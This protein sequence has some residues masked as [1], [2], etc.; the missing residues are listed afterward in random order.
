MAKTRK[1]KR[2]FKLYLVRH[3][4]S[5]ANLARTNSA[6]AADLYT[7]PELTKEGARRARA[8]RPFIKRVI[9]S[10]FV[11]GASSLMRTQQTAQL[12]FNPEKLYIIPYTL[13]KGRA[14]Q[15][16]TP[17]APDLQDQLLPKKVAKI[18][19]FTY[20]RDAPGTPEDKQLEAFLQWLGSH[21]RTITNNGR[22][23]LVIVSHYGFMREVIESLIGLDIET[24]YNCE[25]VEFDVS[26]QNGSAVL[27]NVHGISYMPKRLR[28]WTVK[29]VAKGHGCRLAVKTRR[30]T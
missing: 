10:P 9:R 5:C 4:I 21:M 26:F 19:D 14:S 16:S 3:G 27:K 7:D 18:R 25:L 1:Q 2:S 23:S 15:E 11:V 29:E 17:L 12:L 13:E 6:L 8:L 28:E 22:K 30:R 20:Y 24:I